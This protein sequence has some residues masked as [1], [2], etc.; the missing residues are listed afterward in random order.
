FISEFAQETELAKKEIIQAR[1]ILPYVKIS[2]DIAL[3][4]LN[5]IQTLQIQSQRA[6]HALF[7]AARA[8]AAADHRREVTIEDIQ[9]VGRMT[10]RLRNT[11]WI[12]GSFDQSNEEILVKAFSSPPFSPLKMMDE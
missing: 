8:H 3:A 10:L 9:A 6:E 7:E 11:S 5:V 4:G 1:E 12:E 2:D